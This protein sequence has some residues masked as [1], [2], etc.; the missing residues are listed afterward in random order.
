[1]IIECERFMI[2]KRSLKLNCFSNTKLSS[3]FLNIFSFG[4]SDDLLR[5]AI[6]QSMDCYGLNQI[7]SV[8]SKQKNK[9][10]PATPY[11]QHEFLRQK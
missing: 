3:T 4:I 8:L 7:F 5:N 6:S 10:T 2:N 1:M 11:V 9:L